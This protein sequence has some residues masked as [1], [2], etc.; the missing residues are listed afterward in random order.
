V[1]L[2]AL[3]A[4]YRHH[5][6]RIGRSPFGVYVVA[7]G[8]WYY[9]YAKVDRNFFV[10]PQTVCDPIYSW[11]GFGCDTSGFV[12]TETIAF[13]GSSAGGVNAGAGFTIRLSDNGWKFYIESKY[14]YAWNNRVPTTLVPVT[15]G[16]RFN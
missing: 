9:R 1:N 16:F 4:E 2:Y 7:G 8:G 14:H 10:P 5:I 3:T 13:K 15:F 11:W 6:D 12:I